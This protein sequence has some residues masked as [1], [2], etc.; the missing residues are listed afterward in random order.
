MGKRRSAERRLNKDDRKAVR[1]ERV[2]KAASGNKQEAPLQTAH[3]PARKRARNA[4]TNNISSPRPQIHSGRLRRANTRNQHASMAGGGDTEEPNDADSVVSTPFWKKARSLA[5]MEADAAKALAD[6]LEATAT[7]PV[8]ETS[9][10]NQAE[11]EVMDE[12]DLHDGDWSASDEYPEEARE[13]S[14]SPEPEV[15]QAH[16]TITADFD[17]PYRGV[18]KT[19]LVYSQRK[20]ED[21]RQELGVLW[22]FN[23]ENLTFAYRIAVASEKVNKSNPPV[24]RL[25]ENPYDWALLWSSFREIATQQEKKD[26]RAKAAAKKKNQKEPETARVSVLLQ[27]VD[28]ESH[29]VQSTTATSTIST[30]PTTIAHGQIGKKRELSAAD[31]RK[32]WTEEIQRTGKFKCAE[33]PSAICFVKGNGQHYHLTHQDLS[34]WR[35]L[36]DNGQATVSELPSRLRPSD[37]E[38]FRPSSLSRN[39]KASALG[40]NSNFNPAQ[41]PFTFILNNGVGHASGAPYSPRIAGGGNGTSHHSHSIMPSSEYSRSPT[42]PSFQSTQAKGGAVDYPTISAWLAVLDGD[43]RGQDGQNWYQYAEAFRSAG[44][45]RLNQLAPERCKLDGNI[46]AERVQG[47][48]PGAADYLLETAYEDIQNLQRSS[49]FRGSN[50]FSE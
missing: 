22:G 24:F 12:E 14:E 9:T 28:A 15:L 17:I 44:Y 16:K 26:E 48:A 32:D 37:A 49:I 4:T 43:H 41:L 42:R 34:L 40:Q 47:L 46:L 25:V 6:G 27:K 2:T 39:T 21:F 33:D 23:P 13:Q 3:S 45:T 20:L 7:P 36:L 35:D 30:T 19:I 31:N 38:A 1:Q 50:L 8:D 5:E 11:D 29:V 10:E 18:L